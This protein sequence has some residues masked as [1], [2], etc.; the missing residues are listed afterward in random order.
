[1]PRLLQ[2]AGYALKY[3]KLSSAW[4]DDQPAVFMATHEGEREIVVAIRGTAQLVS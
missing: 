3:V 2:C 1:M 4:A